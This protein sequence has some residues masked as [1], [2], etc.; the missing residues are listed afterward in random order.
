MKSKKICMFICIL[1][2]IY[3]IGGII[4]SFTRKSLSV[5]KEE[6]GIQIKGFE[7]ILKSSDTNIFK[8]EFEKLKTNL[9]SDD[10]NYN[11]YAESLSKLFIIDLYTLSNKKNMYDV[12]GVEFV[13]KDARENYSLNV[14]N[15][16]Y[17]YMEN[18]DGRKQEL[19]EVSDVVINSVEETE[20]LI[21]EEKFDGYKVSVDISYVKDLEYDNKAE[22]ILIKEDKYLYVVE[23]N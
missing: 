14:E 7:Y 6:V 2:F 17:K 12:G 22:I 3:F 23:K 21:G 1:L 4:Y 9:E 8:T 15:T 20:Y 11:E 16:L 5:E 13:Y 19:P 10:I 18:I